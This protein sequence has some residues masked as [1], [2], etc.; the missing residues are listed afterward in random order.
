MAWVESLQKAIHYI[1]EHL[2]EPLTTEDVAARA[3]ASPFH[4]QRMFLLLTDTTVG[5]YI[6]R[7]RLTLAAQE[8]S[9]SDAKVIDLAHKFGY[10]SPE[11]FAK[12]FRKQ[13]GV[14]P[15]DARRGLG[16]LQSYNR[17]VVQVQLRG[18]E[19]MNYRIVEREAFE[20]V[21]KKRQCPCG[22]EGNPNGIA[23]LWREAHA[24][25]TVQKLTGM[26]N[27]DI[28]GLLGMTDNYDEAGN[29]IDYW[30]AAEYDGAS[31]EAFDTLRLPAAK[32]VVFEVTGSAPTAMP[33]AWRA[34]YTEW[35]P[36][37]GYEPLN[38]PALEAYT[39]PDPYRQDAVNH[40][41]LAVK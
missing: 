27:G 30:V 23:E 24:D 5:E 1:E 25:G 28:R 31:P 3:H 39:D 21:G 8:L 10:D 29:T 38:V 6:R 4:F 14:S 16:T 15:T 18:A 7:R 9:T 17:L 33:E 19:P 35:I 2:L 37:N 22:A 13:H 11:A 20:V 41:W 34:I 36:S 40:I 12:A 26:M 32:W